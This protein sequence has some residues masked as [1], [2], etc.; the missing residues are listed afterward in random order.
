MIDS[1]YKVNPGPHRRRSKRRARHGR[2][3]GPAG[4]LRAALQSRAAAPLSGEHNQKAVAPVWASDARIRARPKRTS[5]GTRVQ[6]II[7]ARAGDSLKRTCGPTA[8]VRVR[9]S[10]RWPGNA[11]VHTR[12][13]ARRR[14]SAQCLA[15]AHNADN[16]A[17]SIAEG[18]ALCNVYT[19]RL[20]DLPDSCRSGALR[21]CVYRAARVC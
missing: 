16:C 2:D 9:A 8:G 1:V 12:R 21:L 18:V 17:C 4:L 13:T 3:H 11:R 10:T 7:G 15:T 6:A 20:A 5:A 14:I 19:E